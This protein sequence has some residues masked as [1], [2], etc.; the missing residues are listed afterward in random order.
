MSDHDNFQMGERL[1][2]I[3]G[4]QKVAT[5]KIDNLTGK[6]DSLTVGIGRRVEEHGKDISSLQTESG[7][8]KEYIGAV[9][10]NQKKH[11]DGHWKLITIV[12]GLLATFGT[13]AKYMIG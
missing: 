5:S 6:I 8:L 1:G 10:R 11:E 13:L 9:N 3:E 4:E 7:N 12:I 2:R